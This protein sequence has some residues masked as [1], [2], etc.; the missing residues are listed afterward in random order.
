MRAA[1]T[2]AGCSGFL[3]ASPTTRSNALKIIAPRDQ[4]S[5]YL[6][7]IGEAYFFSRRFEEAAAHLLASLDLAPSSR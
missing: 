4:L 5:T 1:G 2:R 7:G 3:P 6:N